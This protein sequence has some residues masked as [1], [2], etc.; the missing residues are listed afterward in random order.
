MRVIRPYAD[1]LREL[2]IRPERLAGD[3]HLNEYERSET[4]ID[5]ADV[6]FLGVAGLLL[7][8]PP[9]SYGTSTSHD[10]SITVA[11]TGL[12]FVAIRI[13]DGHSGQRQYLYLVSEEELLEYFPPDWTG[14]LLQGVPRRGD[15]LSGLRKGLTIRGSSLSRRCC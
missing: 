13:S 14:A 15:R 7:M 11:V 9:A 4:A 6:R 1:R 5:W 2:G 8:V 12:T 3:P 10:T